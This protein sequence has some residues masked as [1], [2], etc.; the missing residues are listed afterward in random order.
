MDIIY[1]I[2][3]RGWEDKM[4]W[5]SDKRRAFE[6]SGYYWVWTCSDHFLPWKSRWKPKNPSSN[7]F[8]FFV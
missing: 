8:F 4:C 7:F 1:G 6:V 2:S 3:M 5:K